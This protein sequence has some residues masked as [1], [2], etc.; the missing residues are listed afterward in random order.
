MGNSSPQTLYLSEPVRVDN[1]KPKGVKTVSPFWNAAQA[2]DDETAQ[3]I[4]LECPTHAFTTTL[5]VYGKVS[6]KTASG[7][8][9]QGNDEFK[10]GKGAPKVVFMVPYLT[11]TTAVQRGQAVRSSANDVIQSAIAL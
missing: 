9:P 11:N 8:T 3:L 4:D 10:A 7:K 1:P 6:G 5:Q 2:V